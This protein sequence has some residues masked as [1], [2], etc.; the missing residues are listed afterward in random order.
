MD[1][2]IVD[3]G[4]NPF[5]SEI[6][7]AA[8]FEDFIPKKTEELFDLCKLSESFKLFSYKGAIKETL[9]MPCERNAGLVMIIGLGRYSLQK[10]NRE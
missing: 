1:I 5:N 3:S 7:V 10:N 4:G 8:F 6:T 9:V 2:R